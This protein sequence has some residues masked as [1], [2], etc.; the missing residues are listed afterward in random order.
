[1]K[2][3]DGFE[4]FL[5]IMVSLFIVGFGINSCTELFKYRGC[6]ELTRD[7]KTCLEVSK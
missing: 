6:L 7:T 2:D 1:M 5:I 4:W 3:I